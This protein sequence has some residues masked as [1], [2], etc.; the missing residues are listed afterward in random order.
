VVDSQFQQARLTIKT[1]RRDSYDD[2]PFLQRAQL[3]FQ[4]ILGDHGTVVLTGLMPMMSRAIIGCIETLTRSYILAF[5]L[6]TPLM[7]IFIGSLRAGIVSMA[8]NLMP[9]L[10]TLGFMGWTGL[11]LDIFTLLIGC[12]GIGLA[13]D[14]TIHLIHSFQSYYAEH[15]DSRL[16][17]RQSLE[18]T[19]KAL[20]FTSLVLCSSFI[21]YTASAMNSLFNFG[22]LT[23]GMIAT[24]FVCDV[25]VTPALL[26]LISSDIRPDLG[27][28]PEF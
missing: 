11:P 3:D 9:I 23:A 8:P 27:P 28:D 19:G 1:T 26:I 13:V 16:A 17:V 22:L 12:I 7:M 21:I 24:A 5:L 25:L 18:T 2:I 20:L 4:E 6:I 14:D 15:G 10:M